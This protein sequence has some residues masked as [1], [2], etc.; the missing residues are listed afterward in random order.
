MTSKI[1][2]GTK[3]STQFNYFIVKDFV[4]DFTKPE[5]NRLLCDCYN[6]AGKLMSETTT[7]FFDNFTNPK[8]EGQYKFEN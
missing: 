7:I 6:K 3:I 4:L 8:F 2:I 1:K 5:F